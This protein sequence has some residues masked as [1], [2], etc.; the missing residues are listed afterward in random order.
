MS[1]MDTLGDRI[2]A[3][4]ARETGRKAMPGLPLVIRLD[5]NSFS[6]FTAG[7]RRPYDSDLADLMLATAK[8]LLEAT[9]GVVWGYTQSDEI[10]LL[11]DPNAR[12][13]REDAGEPAQGKGAADFLFDGRFSKL[14]S[15]LAGKATARFLIDA[16]RLWP[17][18]VARQLPVFDCRV[19]EV[20]NRE[21]AVNAVLW[22]ELDATKNAVSMAARA[23]FS[24]K[25]LHGKS[26]SEMQEM[27][28]QGHG[29]NFNDYPARFKRGVH[30][31]RRTVLRELSP[32]ALA[33][34][35]PDRRPD[36]PVRR[37]ET[38]TLDLPPL[39]KI[40]NRVEMIFDGEDPAV[41]D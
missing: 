13:S 8:H 41:A 19:F 23:Y 14:T 33:K 34:I 40:R 2:K 18:R 15:I 32:Q 4:E 11:V 25:S 17:D 28:F 12:G 37:R 7:M 10:S 31:Q 30:I 35:P 6:K 20:P 26:G 27:L 22:R 9:P 16:V 36:G 5:G 21:E 24:H 1:L 3:Y 29:V 38:A 39:L